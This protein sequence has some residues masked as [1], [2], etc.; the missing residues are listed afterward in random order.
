M[1]QDC[2][3]AEF[4]WGLDGTVHLHHLIHDVYAVINGTH[5]AV[6][7]VMHDTH[8]AVYVVIHDTHCDIHP[9]IKSK[10]LN[11]IQSAWLSSKCPDHAN[12]YSVHIY[13]KSM[14]LHCI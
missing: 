12:V 8:S 13:V 10:Y 6:Y 9:V 2:P 7:V 3:L 14:C 5:S 1:M 11:A 4:K